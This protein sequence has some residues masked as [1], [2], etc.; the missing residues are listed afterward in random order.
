VLLQI[1]STWADHFAGDYAD[2]ISG[3]DLD[4]VM[5]SLVAKVK[6]Q[7]LSAPGVPQSFREFV[8]RVLMLLRHWYYALFY[9]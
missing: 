9:V 2:K 3:E 5:P 1:E 7:K 6:Q 8:V 4:H